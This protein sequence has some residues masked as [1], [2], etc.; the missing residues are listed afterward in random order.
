MFQ[1]FICFG[2]S[3]NKLFTQISIFGNFSSNFLLCVV[4]Q[5]NENSFGGIRIP[6]TKLN[7]NLKIEKKLPKM[8]KVPIME[9]NYVFET[10]K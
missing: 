4:F 10:E 7:K 3:S 8:G 1:N 6:Q 2:N 5:R 9:K